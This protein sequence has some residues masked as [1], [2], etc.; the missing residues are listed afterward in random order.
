MTWLA[1]AALTLSF[2]M[3]GGM[4]HEQHM[5]QMADAAMGF[6]QDKISHHFLLQDRGGAIEVTAK[7]DDDAASVAAI[8]TH[9]RQIAKAFADGDFSSPLATHGEDP[10]GVATMKRMTGAI[11]YRYTE[12]PAGARVTITTNDPAALDAVHAFLRYQI[13]EHKTGDTV[14]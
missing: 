7:A 8:R 14:K 10:D 4:T 2:Q 11:A 6:D 9:L 1:L 12:L 3:P 5:K 13:R